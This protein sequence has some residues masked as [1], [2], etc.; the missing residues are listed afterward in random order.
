MNA[1]ILQYHEIFQLIIGIS[2]LFLV[3][4]AVILIATKTPKAMGAYKWFLLNLAVSMLFAETEAFSALLR[5]QTHLGFMYRIFC[6][7]FSQRTV[8]RISPY[9]LK[10]SPK[11]AYKNIFDTYFI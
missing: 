1:R 8:P 11:Y 6:R 5:S 9:I 2:N 10:N 4:F 7:F 3:S